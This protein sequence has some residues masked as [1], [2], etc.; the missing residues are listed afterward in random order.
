VHP[1]NF[2]GVL[3][4]ACYSEELVGFGGGL[5]QDS[6]SGEMVDAH[7]A[8]IRDWTEWERKA[9]ALRRAALV[10][11]E[12]ATRDWQSSRRSLAMEDSSGFE[13]VNIAAPRT[14]LNGMAI[15]ALA[16]ALWVQRRDPF[17]G[18]HYLIGHH[19]TLDI[20]HDLEEFLYE[21]EE[22]LLLRLE[23]YVV[24]AG[25]YPTGMRPKDHLPKVLG[26]GLKVYPAYSSHNLDEDTFRILYD[27]LY[28]KLG[29]FDGG[30]SKG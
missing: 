2:E 21:E 1:R 27:R 23:S 6:L 10:L 29:E 24:W 26:S 30:R 11:H 15:E 14:M 19:R 3:L 12:Q 18:S 28:R 9:S 25:K 5:D 22:E 8:L 4:G 20:L 16:K 7:A 13:D 17:D